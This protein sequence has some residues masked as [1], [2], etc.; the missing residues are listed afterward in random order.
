MTMDELMMNK[1]YHIAWMMGTKD[2]EKRMYDVYIGMSNPTRPPFLE[3]IFQ[4]STQI[5]ALLLMEEVKNSRTQNYLPDFN[6]IYEG[7]W[8]NDE[9]A[10][11]EVLHHF[12]ANCTYE[13]IFHDMMRY[14]E[15]N[16]LSVLVG[17]GTHFKERASLVNAPVMQ[18]W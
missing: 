13:D 11:S 10:K 4:E 2:F 1:D 3:D 6:T 14:L 17:D 9:Y 7:V 16:R 15:I 18:T 5:Q 12:D 8:N